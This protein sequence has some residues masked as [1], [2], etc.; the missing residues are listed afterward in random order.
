VNSYSG[1]EHAGPAT[2][3][4]RLN[5]RRHSPHGGK[6][7]LL[8]CA[9]AVVSAAGFSR[10]EEQ[11]ASASPTPRLASFNERV[12][13][14]KSARVKTDLLGLELGSDIEGARRRLDKWIDPSPRSKQ[15]AEE[16]KG[17][18]KV[19]WELNGTDFA[20]IFVK[21]NEQNQIT[22]MLGVL[23]SGKEIPFSEIGE[24]EKAPIRTGQQIAW[25]VL[26]PNQPLIRVV[27]SGSQG[28]AASITIFEV[29]RATRR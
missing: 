15:P 8:L 2:A 20:S 28:K 24:V 7:W 26:R 12:A 21:A 14:A 23:R 13:L 9:A 17:E 4:H 29:R 27:A 5:L 1:P 25:D 18:R 10:A 16:E 19:L 6:I 11:A 3:E 22:Y